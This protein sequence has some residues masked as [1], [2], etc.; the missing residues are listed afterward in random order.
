MTLEKE[1]GTRSQR[2]FYA[3][4]KNSNFIQWQEVVQETFYVEES[5]MQIRNLERL[6]GNRKQIV[7]SGGG[8]RN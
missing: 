5:H 1:K 7:A 3:K 2:T 4:L 6:P 8:G